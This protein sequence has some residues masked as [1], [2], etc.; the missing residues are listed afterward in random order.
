MGTLVCTIEADKERGI[1][2]KIENADDSITQTIAMNGT[3]ITFEVKGQDNTSTI[4]QTSDAINIKC[5]DFKLETL[6][7]M[8]IHSKGAATHQSDDVFAITS[9]KDFS[10]ATDAKS[11]QSAKGAIEI[12]GKQKIAVVATAALEAEG[13]TLSL[14]GKSKAEMSAAAT[15]VEGQAKLDLEASGIA[16]LKGNLTNVTGSMIKMG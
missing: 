2:V 10:I 4:V 11:S 9:K 8:T 7:T 13:A 3:S 5:K 12:S 15:K 6:E 14:K 1:T 16:T